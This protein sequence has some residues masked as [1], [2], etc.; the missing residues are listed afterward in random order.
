MSKIGIVLSGCGVNDGSEIHEAVITMLELDKAGADMLLMAPNIDQLHVINHATGEEMDDSR[1]VLV[2]SA[3]ISRGDI[4]D[5]AVV[6][7]ENVDALIFPGGFGVAKNLSDYAMA[8]VE[9]SVNPDVLR[10]SR[11]V[12]NEGKPIGA[13]CIAPAIMATILSGETELT[14]GFDEQTASDIDAMGAKHVLCPVDEIVVD[15]E[16]KVVSTP[17]YMEAQSIKEAALGIEKLVAEIL[18]MIN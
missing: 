17:A 13:I 18:N 8:G 10:L 3:R 2:E 11:E 15:K 5:I 12:H 16:K 9:C 14:V 7:S 1:N 6:T 4:E